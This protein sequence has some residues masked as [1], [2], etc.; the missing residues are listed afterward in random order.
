LTLLLMLPIIIR[1]LA[2]RGLL[3]LPAPRRRAAW[4]YAL[5][6]GQLSDFRHARTSL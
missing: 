6:R 1:G 3:A 2:L 5:G 4:W